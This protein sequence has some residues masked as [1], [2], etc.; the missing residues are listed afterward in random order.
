M[1]PNDRN[2]WLQED[3]DLAVEF[4]DVASAWQKEKREAPNLPSPVDRKVRA[5]AYTHIEDGLERNWLFGQGPRLATAATLFFAI[6]VYFVFSLPEGRSPELEPNV[7]SR[8]EQ[9]TSASRLANQRE[10][11]LNLARKAWKKTRK[12]RWEQTQKSSA[13]GWVELS[14][15]VSEAGVIEK[16]DVTQS[17]MKI[18]DRCEEDRDLNAYAIELVRGKSY[19][20]GV[21]EELIFSNQQGRAN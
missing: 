21:H 9:R 20:P 18:S 10:D 2:D 3:H 5:F 4:Q 15:V 8:V 17:C 19:E 13:R 16:I 7:D 11:N 14:L 6:G 12:T 1:K